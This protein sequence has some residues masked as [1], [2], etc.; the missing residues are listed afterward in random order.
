MADDSAPNVT[1]VRP[2]DMP[3]ITG[4]LMVLDQIEAMR[5]PLPTCKTCRFRSGRDVEYGGRMSFPHCVK[6]YM[7]LDASDGCDDWEPR[8]TLP[9]C[10][11][12]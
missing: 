1:S 3:L 9:V 11:N 6:D 7:P 2:E 8:F 10:G 5:R 4:I 12:D